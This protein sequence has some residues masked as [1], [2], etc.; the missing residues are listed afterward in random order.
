MEVKKDK[1][2]LTD[3]QAKFLERM[4]QL[5]AIAG[6]AR[7]VGEALSLCGIAQG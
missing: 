4:R 7:S 1:G 5:N 2:K 6:V 3:C